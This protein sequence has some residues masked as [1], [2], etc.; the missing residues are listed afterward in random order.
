MRFEHSEYK[1]VRNRFRNGGNDIASEQK[2]F[3]SEI[4][5]VRTGRIWSGWAQP[6]WRPNFIYIY[7]NVLKFSTD[8]DRKGSPIEYLNFLFD[9]L[10]GI[11]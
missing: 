1:L 2:K 3:K 7:I 4:M 9:L 10:V 11:S 6:T 5:G 8:A